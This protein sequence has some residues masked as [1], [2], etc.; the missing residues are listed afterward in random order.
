M[1]AREPSQF[2]AALAF[3]L[4]LPPEDALEQLELRAVSLD[5]S[6]AAMQAIERGISAYIGRLSVLELEYQR[7]LAQAE[8]TWVRSVIDDLRSH[9]LAW[10]L[11]DFKSRLG[12]PYIDM[13][14]IETSDP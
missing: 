14:D 5:A 4:H 9:R 11:E 6:I 8:L 7:V 1:P 12:N 2:T 3:V 10:N 13:N